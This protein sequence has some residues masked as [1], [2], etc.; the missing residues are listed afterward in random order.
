MELAARRQLAIRNVRLET[1]RPQGGWGKTLLFVAAHIPLGILLVQSRAVGTA[2]ALGTLLVG[3]V[4][5]LVRGGSR[6]ERV[7]YVAAYIAGA[8][9]LWRIAEAKVNWEFGKYA[10]ALVLIVAMIRSRRFRGP[11]VI[12]LYFLLL[13]PSCLLTLSAVPFRLAR[14]FLSF[15]LSGPFSLAVCC[16]FFSGV[17]LSRRQWVQVFFMAMAPILAVSAVA[18]YEA[19]KIEEMVF[20]EHS[21]FFFSAGF[22]P[23]QVSAVLGFGALLVFFCLQERV[24]SRPIRI[25]L[26]AVMLALAT[27]SALTFSRGGLYMFGGAAVAAALHMFRDARA[28]TGVIVVGLIAFLLAQFVVI[29]RLEKFTEGAIVRR[30]ESTDLTGRD[31]VVGSDLRMFRENP[32]LGVGPGMS[33]EVRRREMGRPIAAHTELTRLV[34]EHGT[35]G[36]FSLILMLASGARN[37]VRRRARSFGAVSAAL[38]VWSVLFMLVNALRLVLPSFAFGL[39]WANLR[40]GTVASRAK[41]PR[42]AAPLPTG[43]EPRRP[44]VAPW[45]R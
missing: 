37:L 22:G 28:R 24:L 10:T 39:A 20:I 12:A 30:F 5:A 19:P 31:V 18:L 36:L 32:L 29:P 21:A 27:H 25:A 3:L 38:T 15:N 44:Q 26:F 2:H 40:E 11:A 23:N 6:L 45:A 1:V 34:A 43:R 4:F 9:I 17:S 33:A 13:L 42:R 7:T 41:S 14:P 8:E 35:L 16:W